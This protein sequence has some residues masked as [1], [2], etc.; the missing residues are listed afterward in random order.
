MAILSALAAVFLAVVAVGVREPP[1]HPQLQPPIRVVS[2]T[3]EV[4]F[5]DEVVFSLDAESASPITEITIFYRLA[6]QKVRAY[7]YLEFAP[8][9]HVS[10][11]FT[12]RTSGASYV[13]SGVDIEYHYR[14]ADSQGNTLET[15]PLSLQY[16]DPRYE[17]QEMEMGELAALWHDRPQDAVEEVVAGALRRLAPVMSM[18]GLEAAPP[19][20]AVILNNRQE[21]DQVFPPVSET[22]RR[23]YLYGGFAF[24]EFDLFV[25]AAL[26]EDDI[27]HEATHLLLGEAVGPAM[28]RVPAWLNE[29]LATYFE[30]GSRREST[31]ERAIREGSLL[32]LRAMN[33]VPGTPEGVRLFYAQ[34]WSVVKYMIDTYGTDRMS[35][36]IHAIGS[37]LHT[38]E[39][40]EQVYGASLEEIE[41][42]WRTSLS[43]KTTLAPRPDLGAIASYGLIAAAVT[44]AVVASF[45]RWLSHKARRTPRQYIERVGD[46]EG[47]DSLE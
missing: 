39:A 18:F 7:G 45:L 27:V 17:W 29:G 33:A 14:I 15:P 41:T 8:D 25:V 36:L 32:R 4:H 23:S 2:S 35:A 9:T 47:Y 42:D 24:R 38:N 34:S 20:K 11:D 26:R 10:G 30:S 6:S 12:L 19:M 31:A 22:A 3:H 1:S 40:V 13:P 46:E 21:A 43:E 44:V 28:S 5:P 37:G 16:L